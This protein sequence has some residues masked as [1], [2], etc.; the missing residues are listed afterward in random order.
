MTI[1]LIAGPPPEEGIGVVAFINLPT[2]L[3]AGAWI[4][5]DMIILN[6]GATDLM[7]L[8]FKTEWNGEFYGTIAEIAAGESLTVYIPSGLIVMPSMNA[9]I[10]IHA[11]HAEP[12]GE[13]LIDSTEFKID[14]TKTH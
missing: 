14:D 7:A 1:T 12:G 11:C 9:V 13:L 3:Q 8:V 4:V 10:T 2:E 6:N 5:G